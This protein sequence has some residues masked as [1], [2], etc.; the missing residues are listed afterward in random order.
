MVNDM[1]SCLINAGHHVTYDAGA[2][3]P[4]TGLRET[5]VALKVSNLI[6]DYLNAAGVYSQQFQANELDEI[7]DYANNNEFDLFVSI[8]CNAASNYSAQG[9]ETWYYQGSS[10]SQHLASCIQDQIINSLP[11]TDRGIKPTTGLYVLKHTDMPAALVELAFITNEYDE[12]LLSN[13]HYIDE[14]ARAIARGIT[15]ALQ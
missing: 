1:S 8:H 5:D 12:S 7:T 10:N 2:V 9:T 13:D 15:D 14:F 11:V 6:V 3:S 4:R